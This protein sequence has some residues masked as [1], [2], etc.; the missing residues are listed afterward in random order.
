MAPARSRSDRGHLS[1]LDCEPGPPAIAPPAVRRNDNIILPLHER[2]AKR[3]CIHAGRDDS[4]VGL[5]FES[6]SGTI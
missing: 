3:T 1:Y 5:S 2:S 6:V 4:V